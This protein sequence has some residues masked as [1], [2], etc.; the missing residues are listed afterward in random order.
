[1]S[2]SIPSSGDQRRRS[3]SQPALTRLAP[4][5]VGS[6]MHDARTQ[7]LSYPP[8]YPRPCPS[9]APTSTQEYTQQFGY[10]DQPEYQPYTYYSAQ[11]PH[12][13]GA[14]HWSFDGTT[15]SSSS[16][17]DA[18]PGAHAPRS[19]APHS[20]P[21]SQSQ[22]PMPALYHGQ[23][24]HGTLHHHHS[25]GSLGID[26]NASSRADP[27][28]WDN[29]SAAPPA[30]AGAIPNAS[31]NTNATGHGKP[32]TGFA[33]TA[34]M[35]PSSSSPHLGR[36]RRGTYPLPNSSSEHHPHSHSPLS[37]L[38][39]AVPGVVSASPHP[40][41]HSQN[42]THPHSAHPSPGLSS[43][44]NASSVPTLDHPD[45]HR[46]RPR[47]WSTS[48]GSSPSV[49]AQP[50]NTSLTRPTNAH[51]NLDTTMHSNETSPE[52]PAEYQFQ[53]LSAPFYPAQNNSSSSAGMTGGPVA[54]A[55]QT[56]LS[57]SQSQGSPTPNGGN[58]T[59]GY[60]QSFGQGLFIL[61]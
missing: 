57:H 49:G 38:Q 9:S 27:S 13:H 29:N 7:Y 20:Q 51:L 61:L 50:L 42:H 46:Q 12:G 18:S 41:S 16:S 33:N 45:V 19:L 44:A 26:V 53:A 2:G 56:G 1:M 54:P 30:S 48:S 59:Q 8:P 52:P 47:H 24:M 25:Q 60:Y 3:P 15:A 22:Q 5:M 32:W 58:S 11:P 23:E 34:L 28:S 40:H 39:H 43:V 10:N 36:A 21:Q 6:D 17:S 14:N 31:S 55:G 35:P 4:A 37:S